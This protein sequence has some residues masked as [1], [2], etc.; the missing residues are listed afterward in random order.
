MKK[1]SG[2]L[3][4]AIAVVMILGSFTAVFAAT[5]PATEATKEAIKES[6]IQVLQKIEQGKGEATAE[7]IAK[8]S[9]KPPKRLLQWQRE[10]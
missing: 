3:A 1:R 4:L 5:G 6:G 8:L 2:I 9:C 7:T 10:P